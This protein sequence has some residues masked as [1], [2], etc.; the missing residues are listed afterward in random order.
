MGWIYLDYRNNAN[1]L[2]DNSIIYGHNM[3]NGTMFGSLKTVLESSWQK[4]KD[5]LVIDLDLNNNSYKF[6][7]FSIY[8][9]DYTTDYLITKFDT[10]QEKLN[11]IK[12]IRDRS[13]FKSDE[14]VG[15]DDYI[16][17]LSTCHGK[18]NRRLVVHAVLMKEEEEVE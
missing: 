14:V 1:E 12:M 5:N 16:L 4:N 7:I 18:N 13:E 3:G 2:N 10:S 8:K 9:V 11:F 6:K 17:T 15:E